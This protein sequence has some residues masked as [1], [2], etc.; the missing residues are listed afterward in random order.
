MTEDTNN[1][2]RELP[3]TLLTPTFKKSSKAKALQYAIAECDGQYD[4]II[5]LDADNV[6]KPDF[7][8]RINTVCNGYKAIQCHRCA[9]NLDNDIAVLDCLFHSLIEFR[10]I[11]LHIIQNPRL[12]LNIF[13]IRIPF[14]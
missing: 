7:I 5:I 3:V 6:V 2:L 9:K 4:Y 11:L 13:V 12:T 10:V 14:D 8:T 1:N